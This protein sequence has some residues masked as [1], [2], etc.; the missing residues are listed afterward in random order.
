MIQD[1]VQFNGSFGTTKPRPVIHGQTQ[2]NRRGIQAQQFILEPEFPLP[3]DLAP[4]CLVQGKEELLVQFPG[5]MFIGLRQS[6]TIRYGHPEMLQLAF[7]APESVRNFPQRM[8]SPQ[9]IEQHGD[10]LTPTGESSSMTLCPSPLEE[11][12]KLPPRKKL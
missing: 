8:G 5:T 9:L 11:P 10:E 6:R 12:L 1:K 4:A 3:I 2:I 7:T